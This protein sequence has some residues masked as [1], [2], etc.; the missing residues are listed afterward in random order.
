MLVA[1]RAA[2]FQPE[3]CRGFIVAPLLSLSSAAPI[4]SL[5]PPRCLYL[6]VL[7]YWYDRAHTCRYH[8]F[9]SPSRLVVLRSIRFLVFRFFLL[10]L[11]SSDSLFFLCTTTTTSPPEYYCT[12]LVRFSTTTCKVLGSSL[13]CVWLFLVNKANH[14]FVV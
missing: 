9:F 13:A 7:S 11:S 12:V 1:S 8:F 4:L 3:N 6:L 14:A 10:C 2:M 5:L